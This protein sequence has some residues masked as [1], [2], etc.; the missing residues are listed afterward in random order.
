MIQNSISQILGEL[1]VVLAKVDD[2]ESMML[3]EA[4]LEGNKIV[5]VGAG[6]VGMSL[7]A[8]SMRLGHFGLQSWFL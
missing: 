8:F 4:I 6:R 2:K 5:C 3:V 1:S 7:R